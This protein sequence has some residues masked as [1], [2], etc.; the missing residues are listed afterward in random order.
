MIQRITYTLALILILTTA[1]FAENPKA[2]VTVYDFSYSPREQNE[3]R[4]ARRY[5]NDRNYQYYTYIVPT[6]LAHKLEITGK[7]QVNRTNSV[8]KIDSPEGSPEYWEALKALQPNSNYAISGS[9]RVAGTKIVINLKLISIPGRKIENVRRES[10]E[11]GA[12]L[13]DIIDEIASD[14]ESKV[15]SFHREYIRKYAKT[16]IK[17]F[18]GAIRGFNFGARV[19][20]FWFIGSWAGKF[21]NREYI[22]PYIGYD[23]TRW[24]GV[25]LEADYLNSSRVNYYNMY[26][27]NMTIWG[28]SANVTLQVPFVSF[29]SAGVNLGM[30]PSFSRIV[31][32]ENIY[33][34]FLGKHRHASSTDFYCTLGLF[35]KFTVHPIEFQFGGSYKA[36]FFMNSQLQMLTVYGGIG[37]HL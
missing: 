22:N 37:Y 9:C 20:G 6:T 7:Y 29:F 24:F 5:E 36:L 30:G 3:E 31:H 16:G 4:P 17:G 34:P 35:A 2:T 12:E 10:D 32:Y 19:G 18:Y 11:T 21:D 33:N 15:D 26:K 25:S 1:V 8:L 23:I 28:T 14:S 27:K 13:K